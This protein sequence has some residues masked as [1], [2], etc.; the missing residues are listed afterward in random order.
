MSARFRRWNDRT[1]LDNGREAPKGLA[2][3]TGG[4]VTEMRSQKVG[5][6]EVSRIGGHDRV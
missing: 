2:W 4:L 5:L 3:V 1:R 6:F